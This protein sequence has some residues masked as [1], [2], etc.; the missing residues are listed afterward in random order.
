MSIHRLRDLFLSVQEVQEWDLAA[1]LS[2]RREVAHRRCI[3]ATSPWFEGEREIA[4][5]E[6]H[7]LMSFPAE[8][9]SLHAANQE[10]V[11]QRVLASLLERGLLVDARTEQTDG[12]KDAPP[13]VMWHPTAALA[14]RQLRWRG[15]DVEA[16]LRTI[17]SEGGAADLLPRL[18]QPPEPTLRR[19]DAVTSPVSLPKRQRADGRRESARATCRNFNPKQQ[20]PLDLFAQMLHTVYGAQGQSVVSGVPVLKKNSPSA[21]G[22]HPVEAYLLVQHVEGIA[23]GLYHYRPDTHALEPLKALTPDE[24]REHASL[25]VA[26]QPWFMDAHVQVILAAR[27]QRNFWKYRNHAKA[28]RAVILDAGHL[29]QMQYLAATEL[30]LGAF[31]TAA[32]NEG[33]IEDAFGLD[34]MQEGV[35]AVTGFGWR[36]ER[37]EV[38]EFDPLKQVW[39]DWSPG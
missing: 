22:L 13:S 4:A 8:G 27:F 20:L 34:P 3:K 21:G 30:G 26:R 33:D 28:Y 35:L 25:F 6:L 38:L 36:G 19:Q 37:M 2:G 17:Q 14:H 39:S 23:P 32:I 12:P 1:L 11:D 5:C 7:V 10:E 29:S 9:E 18:G 15:I 24:A 31:I 16:V